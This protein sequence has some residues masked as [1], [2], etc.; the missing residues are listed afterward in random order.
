MQ[1]KDPKYALNQFVM[2]DRHTFE[3]YKHSIAEITHRID[4]ELSKV[5]N[6][7]DF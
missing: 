3:I 2:R 6:K 5:N 4:R 1:E 7:K